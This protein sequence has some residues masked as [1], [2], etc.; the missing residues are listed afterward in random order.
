MGEVYLAEDT[1]LNR[2]VALKFLASH[3]C[4]DADCRARFK[5]EAQAA[6]NLNHP[7]IVT[8]YEVGEFNGR[9]F[10]AMEYV[11]GQPL[12]EVIKQGDCSLDKAIDLSLQICEGLEEAHRAGIT[13]RDIKPAN[14]LVS[15]SGRAKLVDFGLAAV[16][17]AD[18]LTKEGSTLGTIGY[19]SPEQ[20]HGKPTDHRSDL[21]SFG[22]VLY[23]LITCKS[24]FKAETPAA[25]MNA[26]AQQTPEPLA[27][28]KT[29]VPDALQR[30][31]SKLLQRD[32]ALRYQTA[33]DVISDLMGLKASGQS[34]THI[35]AKKKQARRIVFGAAA[36]VIL[37]AAVY[38]IFKFRILT[39]ELL[40]PQQKMLAVL[41]FEN[42]G[43]PDDEYFADGITDEITGKLATIREL[44][45]ISRTST[46][47]YKK[48]TKNI[49]QIAKELGVD[50]ILEGTIRWDK[51]GDTSRVR[52][53]PQLIRVSDDTHLWADTYQRPLT[54]VFAIQTEIASRIADVMS[55]SLRES[56]GAKLKSVP[57]ANL[58][59]YDA[60]LRGINVWTIDDRE[61]DLRFAVQMFERAVAIDSTFALAYAELAIVHAGLYNFLHDLT[62]ERQNRAKMAAGRAI[63]LQPDLARGHLAMAYYYYWCLGAYDQALIE[64]ALAEEE[65]TSDARILEIKALIWRR[66]GKFADAI[67]PLKLAHRLDP[68]RVS[69]AA[70]IGQTY[71]QLR[72]Y[73][74]AQAYLDSAIDLAPDV[75]WAYAEKSKNFIFWRG[76]LVRAHQI[77]ASIPRQDDEYVRYAW[78]VQYRLERNFSAAIKQLLQMQADTGRPNLGTANHL[79]TLGKLHALLKDLDHS[80]TCYDSARVILERQIPLMADASWAHSLLGVA[81][82]GLGRPDD[83]MH[84][85]Q[86]AVALCPVSADAVNAPTMIQRL[87]LIY[88]LVED[89]DAALEQIE[90]LL[91]ISDQFSVHWLKVD[92]DFDP[93]RH[94]PRYQELL[95]K[96]GT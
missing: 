20:V 76:D 43:S 42:L 79:L 38:G 87:A 4:Q 31:V 29:G 91:S 60:Y 68:R 84:E 93:L 19:M 88:V 52:I 74:H 28:Y 23:E 8:V 30:I 45:V 24:P 48:T 57:T 26:I 51:G 58:E 83:A 63:M 36:L 37:A 16:G 69:L 32:P 86:L 95:E 14:I 2:K 3:V 62:A 96:Y 54:D 80:R 50:Y 53:L 72:D 40:T 59:A 13:H 17:G 75:V 77:L 46:M 55:I 9:S 1:S 71:A 64:V 65:Q 66:Q 12:S 67:E 89:Y 39:S 49:R 81:Y 82:A 35:P 15:Q 7:N 41:P 47:Q 18:K 70:N 11:E 34:L 73:S 78:S 61:E 6:A 25:T 90:T 33:A 44:G 10:F 22:A 27:R 21:F 5:R 85:G 92:P 56:E 94:L